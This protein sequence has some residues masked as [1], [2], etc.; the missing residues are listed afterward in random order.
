[1]SNVICIGEAQQKNAQT[2]DPTKPNQPGAKRMRRIPRSDR[3]T[4]AFAFFVL[5]RSVRWLQSTNKP[6]R[7]VDIEEALREKY[8]EMAGRF[9]AVDAERQIL[10]AKLYELRRAA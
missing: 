9:R 8:D 6:F 7:H 10:R 2:A 1:M 4:I 3:E 5:G